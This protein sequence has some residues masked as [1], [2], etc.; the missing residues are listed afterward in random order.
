M[1]RELPVFL[2]ARR[3]QV[4]DC[5]LSRCGL[6][7]GKLVRQSLIRR[8]RRGDVKYARR[9]THS[10]TV[11]VLDHDGDEMAFLYSSAA[12]DILCFLPPG[13]AETA[14][15]RRLQSLGLFHPGPGR[16]DGARR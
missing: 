14:D 3:R 1:N 13:A 11:I 16:L 9:L 8:V 10:R 12:K 2:P 5:A 6:E 7:V 4:K 15:W